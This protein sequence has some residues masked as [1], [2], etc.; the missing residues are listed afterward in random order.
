MELEQSSYLS[1]IGGYAFAEVDKS[2]DRV[3]EQ[4]GED[5]LIDLGV[6]DPTD[7]TPPPAREAAAVEALEHPEQGYPSYI[8]ESSFREAAARWYQRRFGVELDPETEITATLGSKQAVFSLPMALLDEG[9]AALIP[10]PG[11][12]PY[13][14]GTKQRGA[15]PVFMPLLPENDFLPD[16]EA[17]DAGDARRAK[18]MWLNSP[19]NPTTK[20]IPASFYD[21]ALSFCREHE[22]L[23]CSDE[24]Y[25]EMYHEGDPPT[26]LFTR[27]GGLEQGLVIHS[28][29]KRSNMT[30][31][32]IGFV[33]GRSEHLDLFKEV[34]TNMHSG[35][36]QILQA[37]AVG[38][39]SD[40]EHV[41]EMRAMYTARRDALLD[42]LDDAGFRDV[43]AEGGFYVWAQVPS[44]LD[45]LE[46][47]RRLLEE[48]GVNTT[49][50]QAL[51]QNPEYGED[52]IR[53]ALIQDVD[54]TREAGR[55]IADLD[56][57]A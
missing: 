37:A 13:T 2:R 49:P 22:I 54:R 46:T 45:S 19:N 27:E 32:R 10:D 41:E 14:T 34:Q 11:Y 55:R 5:Y 28:L 15:D 33:A 4:K 47:T 3:I 31:Y 12:P 26:S 35:Q 6:G 42:Y 44:G 48:T 18:I 52:F 53:F 56:W 29:S 39:Y 40:E 8:G 57:E 51:G 9:D 7:P 23:L 38:A 21:R 30:N 17:I 36:A 25:S 43:Y 20:I 24:A 50:G 1:N 16:L